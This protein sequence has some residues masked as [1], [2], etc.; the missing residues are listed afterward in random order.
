MNGYKVRFEQGRGHRMILEGE[1]PI[2][3]D[4]IDAIQLRML[5]SCDVPGLM[6]LETEELDGAVSLRY[7]L[8]GRRMLSQSFRIARWTME[9][10][11][12]A[13]C[14]LA[15]VLE[16][17]RDYML[18][19]ERYVL[20]DDFIFVGEGWQD[21]GFVYLPLW[22]RT[23]SAQVS[24]GLEKLIVR[25]MMN[26]EAP[27]GSAMQQLL[28]LASSP[29]FSPAILRRYVRQYLAGPS[30]GEGETLRETAGD[31]Y[32]RSAEP[33][34]PALPKEP[35]R[36]SESAYRAGSRSSAVARVKPSAALTASA[37]WAASNDS[38]G[39]KTANGWRGTKASLDAG[40]SDGDGLEK[41]GNRNPP[42]RRQPPIADP[43]S[44]SGLLGKEGAEW[45]EEESGREASPPEAAK[46]RRIWL[47]AG[48]AVAT[49]AVWRF[50]YL[51]HPGGKGLLLSAGVTLLA[52]GACV[53]MWKD[54]KGKTR[55]GPMRREGD[56]E[57][58]ELASGRGSWSDEDS[59]D[60]GGA[61]SAEPERQPGARRFGGFGA[62][63]QVPVADGWADDIREE[64]RGREE[65]K[66]SW[67]PAAQ[68]GTALLAP[69]YGSGTGAA[70]P[71]P[72]L[73]WDHDG[74]MRRIKLQ[75]D[76]LVI[77]RSREAA[78]HVD[79]TEGISRAHLEL[80]RG[81]EAWQARDLGSRNGSWLNGVPM[82][83]YECYPLNKDDS[84][85]IASSLYRY[86][87]GG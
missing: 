72:Y 36:S 37:D 25:W 5:R 24:S 20:E 8:S 16:Q 87:V 22:R 26:V 9:D 31:A 48:A 3:V 53:F 11:M 58:P 23:A 18:D 39:A 52:A 7:S 14:R 78:Q 42:S 4:E 40:L 68:E 41:T 57:A 85:Q 21:L 34:R 63:S 64:E 67:L 77:G 70:K 1:P 6:K 2:A 80:V 27:D 50:A 59:F 61:A 71:I 35:P 33:Y 56:S 30:A 81:E 51:P 10:A 17:G 66:T 79:E 60:D 47:V 84:I 83:P 62:P 28:R 55:R 19:L 45:D 12:G 44:L 15:E 38:S 13:L 43:Q 46:K 73:E 75:G 69:N 29:D 54:G 65:Q 86:K 49:A 32:Y 76:T 74:V 82:A